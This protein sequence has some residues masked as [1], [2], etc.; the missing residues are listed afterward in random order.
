M[1]LMLHGISIGEV[2]SSA[3]V[4][5]SGADNIPLQEQDLSRNICSITSLKK[6][7]V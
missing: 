5:A 4:P 2:I 3:G 1:Y 6:K 7:Y